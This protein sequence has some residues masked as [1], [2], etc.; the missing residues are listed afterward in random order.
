MSGLVGGEVEDFF[1]AQAVFDA[2]SYYVKVMGILDEI[3]VVGGYGQDGAQV[4]GG[5][6]L[7]VEGVELGEIVGGDVAL[8]V[9]ATQ[10]DTAEESANRGLEVDDEVGRREEEGERGIEVPIGGPVAL[11]DIASCVEVAGEY[12]SIF[13]N[14]AVLQDGGRVLHEGIVIVEAA[15]EE[16]YLRVKGPGGHVCIEVG[17]VGIFNDR[18]EERLPAQPLSQEGGE[19]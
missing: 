18:L 15:R 17:E 4:E 5:D 6:P 19:A 3:E 12:F 13:V 9:A 10:A 7:I 11:V 8:E 1:A 16:E 2:A 14:G